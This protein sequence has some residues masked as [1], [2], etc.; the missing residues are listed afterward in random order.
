MGSRLINSAVD[1]TNYVLFEMG[2]PHT[3]SILICS[4]AQVDHPNPE[5]ETVKTLDV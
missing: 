2:K 1:A 4:K 5:G 3:F